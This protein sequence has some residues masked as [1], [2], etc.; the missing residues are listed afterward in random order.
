V[1]AG[2]PLNMRI[3]SA[4]SG[5][6]ESEPSVTFEVELRNV[7]DRHLEF[8]VDPNLADFEPHRSDVPYRFLSSS[9]T[10]RLE[11]QQRSWVSQGVMLYGSGVLS[12][13]TEDLAAGSTLRIRALAALGPNGPA[14]SVQTSPRVGVVLL[15]QE[16]EVR[17]QNGYLHQTS[18]Q[19]L[20]EVISS[21]TVLLSAKP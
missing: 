10:V 18:K 5:L 11:G 17:K 12:E 15:L 3:L 13:S 21:N 19:I 6:F 20:P 2:G 14:A 9:I 7:S 8:P 4:T 1:A 16:N